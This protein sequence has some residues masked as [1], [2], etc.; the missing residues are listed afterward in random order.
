MI[1]P[2]VWRVM[3]HGCACR[4]LQDM[5]AVVW[6]TAAHWHFGWEEG[7]CGRGM[8]IVDANL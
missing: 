1:L 4:K 8:D 3:P 6:T 2:S 5:G 7:G